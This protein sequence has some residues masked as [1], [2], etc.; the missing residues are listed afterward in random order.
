MGNAEATIGV[1]VALLLLLLVLLLLAVL[2]LFLQSSGQRL[3]SRRCFSQAPRLRSTLLFGLS[4][5]AL[6]I[7][8]ES[9]DFASFGDLGDLGDL[10]W[11][12]AASDDPTTT[13]KV[14]GGVLMLLF[15]S[16]PADNNWSCW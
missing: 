5:A 15:E 2:S 13:L 12:A 10:V 16:M 7:F 1:L 8:L 11:P 3:R 9:G 6:R 4:A 14:V